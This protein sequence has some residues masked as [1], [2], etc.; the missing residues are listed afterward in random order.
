L[1]E[2]GY[3][4]LL[5]LYK[6]KGGKNFVQ[7][8]QNGYYVTTWPPEGYAHFAPEKCSGVTKVVEALSRVHTAGKALAAKKDTQTERPERAEIY[9][10]KAYQERL[11]ELLI[12]YR[13]LQEKRLAND[14]ER[15]YAENF[16][17]FYERGQQA[18]QRMVLASSS[19]E[20]SGEAGFLIGNFLPENMLE[21]EAGIIFLNTVYCPKGLP[22]HDLTLFLKMYLPLQ[23]WDEAVAL[24]LLTRYQEKMV[25]G[26]QEKHLLLAQLSF[27]GRFCLYTQQYLQGIGNVPEL[28]ADTINYLCEIYWHDRCLEKLEKCLWGE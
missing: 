19:A 3:R 1:A 12:F 20:D 11:K 18:I 8:E 2:K 17:G 15:L 28:V 14:F 6:T 24:K 22:I 10:L 23:K 4:E 26:N 27:P 5:L 9:W 16:E 7:T 13:Y 21:T 25:L